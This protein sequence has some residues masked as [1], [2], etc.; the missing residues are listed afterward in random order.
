M[1]LIE[2]DQYSHHGQ[3]ALASGLVKVFEHSKPFSARVEF[4]GADGIPPIDEA[5]IGGIRRR[6]IWM[7][8]LFPPKRRPMNAEWD[9]YDP[10]A[11]GT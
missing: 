7:P 11:A 5:V 1:R 8:T 9:S 10:S 4:R 3:G 6:F 2:G